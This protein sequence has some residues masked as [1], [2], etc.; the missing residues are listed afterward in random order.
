MFWCWPLTALAPPSLTCGT[1]EFD[2]FSKQLQPIT[3][4]SKS[5]LIRLQDDRYVRLLLDLYRHKYSKLKPDLVIPIYNGALGF[6]L[7]YGSD[8]FSDIPIVFGGVEKQFIENRTLGPHISGV[9]NANSYRETLD[10][11]LDLHPGTRQVA[12]VAGAG[13]I[14]RAWGSESRQTY[15][16]YEDRIDFIDLMG[17]SMAV[18]LKKVANLPP[19]TV[20]IYITLLEDGD[21]KKFTAPESLSQ[22]SRAANAPVYSFW[23]LVLGHGIVGGYLSNA[24]IKG[25]EVAELGLRILNGEKP[26][27]LPIT[28]ESNLQHKFDWRQLKRWSIPEDA[29]PPG[30]IV[31][32]KEFTV[33]DQYKGRIIVATVLLT[34]QFLLITGLLISMRRRRRI[35]RSR[36]E[37]LGFETLMA[38]LSSDLINIAPDQVDAKIERTFFLCYS[39]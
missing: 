26:A 21:G 6:V 14:G 30:S 11:A 31:R 36:D 28:Q 5:N 24:E 34:L 23:D 1:V 3:L 4:K 16:S 33:W 8:L 32:F 29:L 15:R 27:D 2:R 25:N 19:Q 10:L 18:I 39:N 17:L 20:V 22:I 9:L 7:R 35:E 38:K 12:I 37:L 13:I